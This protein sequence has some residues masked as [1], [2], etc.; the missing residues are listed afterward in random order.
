MLM[1]FTMQPGYVCELRQMFNSTKFVKSS[2]I[3]ETMKVEVVAAR[4]EMRRVIC[5]R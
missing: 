4:K 1:L 2:L 5:K 3:R